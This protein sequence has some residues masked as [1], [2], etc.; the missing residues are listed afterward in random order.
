[1]G[2]SWLWAV[3][4][5]ALASTGFTARA[6][7]SVN[8]PFSGSGNTLAATGFDGVYNLDG[9][10][11]NV[12]GGA[13]TTHTLPGDTFGNYEVDPDSAANQFYSVIDP[14]ATTTLEGKV[15]VSGLNSNFHGGGIWMGTDEDHYAR[16]GVFHNTFV[17]G[18]PI[19]IELLRE[20]QDRWGGA[21]PPGQGDD[22]VSQAT[23]ISPISPMATPL[24]VILRLVRTGNTVTGSYSL[25]GGTTFLPAGSFGGFALPGDPQGLGSNTI[26]APANY[27]VGIYAVGGGSPQG[28][29][30]FDSLTAVSTPEPGS[31]M[32]VALSGAGLLVRRRRAN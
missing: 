30:V 4:G 9:T 3:A 19:S 24:D 31:A 26:E 14:L 2:R 22:I 29:Y 27:K 28:T 23:G 13:L 11:F 16:L 6:V 20:N 17:G 32:L 8:L 21:T 5:L 25:N 7:T 15:T 18:G 12:G 10:G 1:M